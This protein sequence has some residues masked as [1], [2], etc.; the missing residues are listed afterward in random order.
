MNV[1]MIGPVDLRYR[2]SPHPHGKAPAR[3]A[4]RRAD[5]RLSLARE[6][7]G[8]S[9]GI[10]DRLDVQ[11]RGVTNIYVAEGPA[12]PPRRVTAYRDDDGQG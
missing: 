11:R 2:S 9:G 7:G 4:G 12:F 5:S 1:R 8:L 10:D 6:P 3:A